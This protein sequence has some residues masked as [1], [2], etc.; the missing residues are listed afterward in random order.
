MALTMVTFLVSRNKRTRLVTSDDILT[1]QDQKTSQIHIHLAN[2]LRN[3][4]AYDIQQVSISLNVLPHKLVN[5]LLNTLSKVKQDH[6]L[7]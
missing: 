2:L 7:T 1:V 3:K 4:F 6:N 5:T